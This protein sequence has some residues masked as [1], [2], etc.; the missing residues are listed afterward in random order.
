MV[1]SPTLRLR[2]APTEAFAFAYD[3]LLLGRAGT[4][5]TGLGIILGTAA[6]IFMVTISLTV[7]AQAD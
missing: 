4:S 1:S 5:L 3:T 7:S 2:L 6:L